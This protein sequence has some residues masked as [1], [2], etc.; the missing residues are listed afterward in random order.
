MIDLL[1]FSKNF[2]G[3]E[4]FLLFP[5]TTY[6]LETFKTGVKLFCKSLLLLFVRLEDIFI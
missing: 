6:V 2:R 1:S 5:L 3:Q 4:I